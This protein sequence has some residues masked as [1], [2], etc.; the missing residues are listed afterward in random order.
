VGFVLFK[1]MGGF[2]S[3]ILQVS[4]GRTMI[5]HWVELWEEELLGHTCPVVARGKKHSPYLPCM[6]H[7]HR[8]TCTYI[9]YHSPSF[10]PQIKI[11]FGQ[12]F[13]YSRPY[14]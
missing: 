7:L 8:F 12:L 14:R 11:F 2:G 9:Y 4:M 6:I 5:N 3:N 10:L 1:N 13:R